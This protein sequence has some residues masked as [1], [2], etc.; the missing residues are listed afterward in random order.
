M[1][2]EVA[3][4][5]QSVQLARQAVRSPWSPSARVAFRFCFVYFGLYCLG[6]QIINSVLAVP[7]IEVPDWGTLWPIRPMVFWVGAQLFGTKLPLVYSGSGSGDKVYDWVMVFCMLV[8][9]LIATAVWSFLDR[10]R[11]GYP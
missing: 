5:P 9:A 8:A 6:T 10:K 3:L 11:C 4:E 2:V 1:H 7:K